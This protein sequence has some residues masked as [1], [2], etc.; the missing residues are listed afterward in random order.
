MCEEMIKLRKWLD[1]HKIKWWDNS[2]TYDDDCYVHRTKIAVGGREIS[3]INGMGTY[4][5]FYEVGGENL[6]LLEMYV[7]GE[8]EPKG[9]LTAQQ[10]VKEIF[11]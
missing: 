2:C 8:G 4:G 5:G 10:V 11:E 3:V 9:Y 7:C 6:G 1:E